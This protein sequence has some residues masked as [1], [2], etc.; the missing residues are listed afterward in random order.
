M[1]EADY[2]RYA[3]QLD[4]MQRVCSE[5]E[6]ESPADSSEAEQARFERILQLMHQ[7]GVTRQVGNGSSKECRLCVC[8]CVCVCVCAQSVLVP[9]PSP[10]LQLLGQP[11]TDLLKDMVSSTIL[12]VAEHEGFSVP[13]SPCL[14]SPP[15]PCQGRGVDLPLSPP[16]PNSDQCSVM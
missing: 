12:S 10:Q 11:P 8:V 14:H 6:S 2:S 7:V 9:T 5:F 16:L 1:S 3:Q 15:L 4:V 13:P